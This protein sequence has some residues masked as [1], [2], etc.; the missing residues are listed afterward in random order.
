MLAH[1]LRRIAEDIGYL[2]KARPVSEQ[3]RR[4]RVPE[5]M[6]MSARHHRRLEH[7][8]KASFGNALHSSFGRD[9][10]QKK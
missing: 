7:G 6:G 1:D 3:L 5:P 4:Q 9:P 8:S 10:F 2:F